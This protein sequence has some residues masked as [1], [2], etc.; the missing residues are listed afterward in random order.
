MA[1]SDIRIRRF[2][3]HPHGWE[4]A[5]EPHDGRWQVCIDENGLPKLFL[6]VW[7]EDD[8]RR[9]AGLVD[10]DHFS[11]HPIADVVDSEATNED[12]LTEEEADAFFA[13]MT[14]KGYR[15]PA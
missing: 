8:G 4:G 11:D 12:L 5:I 10:F 1:M 2:D 3:N 6:R 9:V 7:V 14:A 13:E 15:C